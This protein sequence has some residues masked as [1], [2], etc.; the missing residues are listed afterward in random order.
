ML[1]V[2]PRALAGAWLL[3]VENLSA[4][5]QSAVL[6]E[7][8]RCLSAP[9]V[10]VFLHKGVSKMSDFSSEKSGMSSVSEASLLCRRVAEPRPIGDSVKSAVV[11]AAARLGFAFTRTRDIWYG[12]ARRIDSEE[13][14]RL[15]ECAAKVEARLAVG[16]LVALRERL[17][18][19]DPQFHGPTISALDD[20]LRSMGCEVRNMV[21]EMGSV[22]LRKE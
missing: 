2:R 10:Y 14:D 5:S 22:A 9:P 13:M 4:L 18:Q 15:R 7:L 19:T 11:R 3:H 1:L 12:H 20:A 16:N 17:A 21:G 8:Y 6:K